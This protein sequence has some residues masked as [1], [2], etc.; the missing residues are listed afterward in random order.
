MLAGYGRGADSQREGRPRS[1]MRFTAAGELGPDLRHQR[2]RDPHRRGQGGRPGP[3]PRR[4]A[5]R[6]DPRRRQRQEDRRPTS[7]RMVVLLDKD[8]K[9]VTTL[10]RRREGDQ[11]PRR[12]DRLLVRGHPGR[13]RRRPWSSWASRASTPMPVATTTLPSPGSPSPRS[14]G[15]GL[16]PPTS[17][18][19]AADVFVHLGGEGVDRLHD[20]V[21]LDVGLEVV[22]SHLG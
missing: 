22:G 5:R 7:T 10:R 2:R 15:G 1:S 12:P 9:P 4:P 11:R 21:G 13:R 6:P 3:Q 18:P 19:P 20:P 16:H 17:R 8:G 14:S